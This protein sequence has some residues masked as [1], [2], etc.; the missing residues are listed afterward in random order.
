MSRLTRERLRAGGRGGWAPSEKDFSREYNFCA[1]LRGGWNE[2]IIYSG[3]FPGE[4]QEAESTG[5]TEKTV[6]ALRE[7]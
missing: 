7:P 3:G 6:A 4:G 2:D 5:G 1:S